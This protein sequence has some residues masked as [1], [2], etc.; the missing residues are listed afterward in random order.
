MKGEINDDGFQRGKKKPPEMIIPIGGS[1]L[2]LVEEGR[3]YPVGILVGWAV[4]R[5]QSWAEW[6][7]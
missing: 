2:S 3:V 5:F 1:H 7:P 6:D 4:G